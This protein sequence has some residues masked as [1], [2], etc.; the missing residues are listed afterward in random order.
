MTLPNLSLMFLYA[1]AVLFGIGT[2]LAL[3]CMF[4]R[5]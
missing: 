4:L 3:I 5:L 1:G 2:A